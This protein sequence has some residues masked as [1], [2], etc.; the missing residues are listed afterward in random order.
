MLPYTSAA[1]W[2]A[3]RTP[4]HRPASQLLSAAQ[5][6]D[7]RKVFADLRPSSPDLASPTEQRRPPA[8]GKRPAHTPLT[9]SP[10]RRRGLLQILSPCAAARAF[11][12][13][14]TS[15]RWRA[16]RSSTNSAERTVVT[17]DVGLGPP[18]QPRGAPSSAAVTGR[19]SRRTS[20][21]AASTRRRSPRSLRRTPGR[22]R[23][24]PPHCAAPG[25]DRR[26]AARHRHVRCPVLDPR[27]TRSLRAAKRRK[28]DSGRRAETTVGCW[29]TSGLRHA[30]EP[31]QSRL[32]PGGQMTRTSRPL[33]WA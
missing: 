16:R 2:S 32:A 25:G 26:P 33:A 24:I 12:R 28:V 4:A 19:R 27:T 15:S 30:A 6:A 10:R 7:F 3:S 17:V 20:S 31:D 13:R 21:T 22:A 11:W 18:W 14:A 5:P 1:C 9:R 23:E 8:G 29:V